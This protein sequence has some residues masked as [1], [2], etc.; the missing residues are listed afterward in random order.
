MLFEHINE[1]VSFLC[2][3]CLNF[4]PK[5]DDYTLDINNIDGLIKKIGNANLIE[6]FE[7]L[8]SLEDQEENTKRRAKDFK[9]L[10]KNRYSDIIPYYENMI[11]LKSKEYINASIVKVRD[12]IILKIGSIDEN[13]ISS[14]GPLENTT[15][16]FW[17]MVIENNVNLIIMLCNTYESGRLKCHKYW[18]G[19]ETKIKIDNSYNI[20]ELISEEKFNDVKS[21]CIRKFS[22]KNVKTDNELMKVNQIHFTG[23]PDHG[24]PDVE[25]TFP[26]MNKMFIYVNDS[27]KH[28]SPVVVHCSAGI[29][30]T[31]TFIS[32]YLNWNLINKIF[33]AQL[34]QIKN[35][36]IN[37]EIDK[38]NLNKKND[39]E[40]S[41]DIEK[42]YNNI[43]END[44]N[45]NY[46]EKSKY[47]DDSKFSNNS[48]NYNDFKKLNKNI[49]NNKLSNKFS[50]FKSVLCIKSAR[51]YSVENPDQYKFIYDLIKLHLKNKASKLLNKISH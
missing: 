8:N 12:F 5:I 6:E 23:W 16:D 33:D 4:D 35:V 22:I 3:I 27:M 30:R 36:D 9:H 48:E 29:G 39:Y 20:V 1:R 46:Y 25:N 38:I 37:K 50:I 19:K 15:S 18:P 28:N 7:I 10:K 13:F 42:K 43:I 32:S 17:E 47:Y 34:E 45:I 11:K 21:L 40:N 49:D 14:Q 26:I 2:L 24:V 44:K 31:G 51:C 41:K